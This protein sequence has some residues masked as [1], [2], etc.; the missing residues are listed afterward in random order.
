[1]KAVIFDLDGTV[2]DTLDDIV[3]ALNTC[4]ESMG[5]RAQPRNA[6]PLMIGDGL[7]VLCRRVLE[8]CSG[9]PPGTEAIE[10]LGR[11][12]V[13][14]Y[15][16][17]LLDNTRLFP[18]IEGLLSGLHAAGIPLAVLSNKPDRHTR[19]IVEALTPP[20]LFQVVFGHRDGLPRKPDPAG[21]LDIARQL[22]VEPGHC[23][24]IGDS[25]VDIQTAR[26]AGMRSIG[27]LWGFRG[28]EELEA[29]GAEFIVGEP[30][31]I[32][33]ILL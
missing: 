29:A 33:K 6:Y 13:A 11:R 7:P 1:M 14:Y 26:A 21:A 9:S 22:G 8:A 18:G 15:A 23:F 17:H 32:G 4:L 2:A 25:D 19:R 27:V 30:G 10:E 31:E 16:E 20:G 24:F 3:K 5:E 28:R 12:V